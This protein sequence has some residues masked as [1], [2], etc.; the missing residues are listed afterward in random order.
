MRCAC[1]MYIEEERIQ[2]G[3]HECTD[4][5]EERAK[6]LIQ[7]K[8]S[9]ITLSHNKGTLVYN[10]PESAKQ[11]FLDSGRKDSALPSNVSTE[12]NIRV[13][14]A[15]RK[16][17][18]TSPKKFNRIAIL[19]TPDGIERRLLTSEQPVPVNSIRVVRLVE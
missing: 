14:A 3:Y 18:N 19:R 10:S 6:R 15:V 11:A 5:G 17:K 1:G 8:K 2:L 9:R 13:I 16:K 4:C 7:E 12:S